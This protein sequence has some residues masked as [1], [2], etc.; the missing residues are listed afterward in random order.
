MRNKRDDHGDQ[1]FCFFCEDGYHKHVSTALR[2]TM[3]TKPHVK[4]IGARTLRQC[5]KLRMDENGFCSHDT[6]SRL[7][8]P[9]KLVERGQKARG[10]ASV[11]LSWSWRRRLCVCPQCKAGF[12]EKKVDERSMCVAVC[13]I[14]HEK[15]R[16]CARLVEGSTRKQVTNNLP[17]CVKS[18]HCRNMSALGG[19]YMEFM[20]CGWVS[21][22]S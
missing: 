3:S 13:K 17:S 15:G 4:A 9:L 2:R 20:Q 7:P 12:K 5:C 21:A 1:C 22:S 18:K 14:L 16:A 10:V 19:N 11:V 8:D 6:R